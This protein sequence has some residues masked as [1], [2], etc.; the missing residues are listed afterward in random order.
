MGKAIIIGGKKGGTGKSTLA[1]NLAGSYAAS[2]AEVIVLDCDDNETCIKFFSRRKNT[3]EKVWDKTWKED[4]NLGSDKHVKQFVKRANVSE[5]NDYTYIECAAKDKDDNLRQDITNLREKYDIVIVDTGG[6]QNGAFKSALL[7]ADI[8]LIPTSPSQFE[9]EQ[10]PPI[11]S[12]IQQME[13]QM[14]LVTGDSEFKLDVRVILNEVVKTQ[15]TEIV[16]AKKAL[17][18]CSNFVSLSS[19]QIPTAK[20]YKD[21]PKTGLFLDDLMDPRRATFELLRQEI[22]GERS[23]YMQKVGVEGE[24]V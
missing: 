8:T 17:D 3:F 11:F 18:A 23:V 22:D 14:Q 15:S 21:L 13:E 10:L 1:V 20:I 6:Y 2:G 24:V 7:A 5:Q 9:L 16:D 4:E 19:V 12:L